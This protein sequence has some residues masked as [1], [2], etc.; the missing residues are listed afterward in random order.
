M[1]ELSPSPAGQAPQ[2]PFGVSPATAPTPNRGYEA[3]A[4]Q[5]M[6][7]IT[8]QLTEILQLT[9]VQSD[10]GKTILKMLNDASKIA[11]PGSVGPAQEKNNIES[12]AMKNAANNQ[13]MAQLKQQMAGG[14]APGAGGP[15]G[16]A[17]PGGPPAGMPMPKAA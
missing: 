7:L 16:G 1:P 2:P 15:P 13:Q 12:M 4:A 11:P 5:K 6:G 3:A 8:K 17:P 10:M 14:G 9:G